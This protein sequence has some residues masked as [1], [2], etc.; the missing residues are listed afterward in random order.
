MAKSVKNHCG[1]FHK[2]M[3]IQLE[4]LKKAINEDKWYL[5]EEV[6]HDIGFQ[7]AKIDFQEKY[8]DDWAKDFQQNY[9]NKICSEK[10]TCIDKFKKS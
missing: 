8:L 7:A 6:G 5:S 3:Q 2:F 1:H 4:A 9:C 10:D